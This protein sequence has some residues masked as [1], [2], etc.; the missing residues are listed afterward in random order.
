MGPDYYNLVDISDTI[1]R[2]CYVF[3]KTK[4]EEIKATWDIYKYIIHK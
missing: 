3:L 2:S 4:L 1:T